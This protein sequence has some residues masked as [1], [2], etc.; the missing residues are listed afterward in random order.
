MSGR[1]AGVSLGARYLAS[2]A[3]GIV[4]FVFF[5][6]RFL[7]YSERNRQDP[8]L[9]MLLGVMAAGGFLLTLGMKS[10]RFRVCHV[11]LLTMWVANAVLIAVDCSD[12]PTNHNLAPFEFIIIALG[13]LPAYAGAGLGA[14][15]EKF[16]QSKGGG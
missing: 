14:L 3:L 11:L 13:T 15:V 4:L 9:W 12:D 16:T 1:P 2:A 5:I 10:K 7:P 6:W 8:N